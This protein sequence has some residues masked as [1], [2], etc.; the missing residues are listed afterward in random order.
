MSAILA[1]ARPSGDSSAGALTAQH[2]GAL[3]VARHATHHRDAQR[4][5]DL[6]GRVAVADQDEARA[7]RPLLGGLQFERDVGELVVM[8]A[9]DQ[10]HRVCAADDRE[11]G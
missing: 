11:R 10:Q 2:R 8:R 3:V 5:G 9:G 7:A 1:A 4:L 6:R